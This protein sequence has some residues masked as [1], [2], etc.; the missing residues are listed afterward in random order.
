MLTYHPTYNEPYLTQRTL[1]VYPTASTVPSHPIPT[2]KQSI[3][4]KVSCSPPPTS[5]VVQL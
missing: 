3:I 5:I 1:A 2:P 4:V